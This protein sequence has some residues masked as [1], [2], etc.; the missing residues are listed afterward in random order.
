MKLVFYNF[1]AGDKL[2]SVNLS[3]LY[4][5]RA[6]CK[7]KTGDCRGCVDDCDLALDLSPGAP[8]P[9][10]RRA[11]AFE[12]L[13]RSV[14]F[15]CSEFQIASIYVMLCTSSSSLYREV[16]GSSPTRD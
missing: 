3:V 11:M 10:L 7:F 13:E 16:P 12:T 15:V 1:G 2:Q 9:I 14:F 4:S 6:A 5:N 8:K